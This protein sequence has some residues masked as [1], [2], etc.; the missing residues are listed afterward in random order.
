MPVK[1]KAG[2][3]IYLPL[4]L[5]IFHLHVSNMKDFGTSS[6]QDQIH[7][8]FFLCFRNLFKGPGAKRLL[9]ATMSNL[10]HKIMVPYKLQSRIILIFLVQSTLYLAGGSV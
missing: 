8:I 5:N 4:L 2:S 6:G 10:L 3:P 9:S 7:S 1:G